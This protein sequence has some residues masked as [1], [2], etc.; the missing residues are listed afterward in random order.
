[1]IELGRIKFDVV[2]KADLVMK[3]EDLFRAALAE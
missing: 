2:D 1:L 3:E